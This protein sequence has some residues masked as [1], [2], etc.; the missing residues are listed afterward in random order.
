MKKK[1]I[2]RVER[3]FCVGLK[4]LKYSNIKSLRQNVKQ[5]KCKWFILM[6]SYLKE[7][8]A[9]KFPTHISIS[10]TLHVATVIKFSP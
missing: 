7:F 6:V 9:F 1:E 2:K 8:N 4:I 5:E 3:L 10:C